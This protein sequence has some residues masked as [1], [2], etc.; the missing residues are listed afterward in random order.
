MDG[1]REA[2]NWALIIVLL[3]FYFFAIV[4]CGA[5]GLGV[6][7]GAPPDEPVPGPSVRQVPSQGVRESSLDTGDSGG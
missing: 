5:P 4:C 3:P 2:L 1:C 7:L 6:G